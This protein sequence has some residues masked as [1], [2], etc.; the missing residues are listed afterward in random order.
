MTKTGFK[1]FRNKEG[2]AGGME[3]RA[4]EG[5]RESPNMTTASSLK[6]FCRCWN[7]NHVLVL[8]LHFVFLLNLESAQIWFLVE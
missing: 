1:V 4:A 6:L 7:L 5:M 8:Q 3:E 2:R